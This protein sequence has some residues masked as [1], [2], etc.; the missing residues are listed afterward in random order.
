M[1]DSGTSRAHADVHPWHFFR[2][3]DPVSPAFTI[4]GVTGT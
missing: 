4:S 2:P 3:H 1:E